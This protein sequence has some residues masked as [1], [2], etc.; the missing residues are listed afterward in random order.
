MNKRLA[1]WLFLACVVVV[2]DQGTKYLI[3]QWLS[4]GQ[5]VPVTPF[6][7]LV[8]VYNPGA[9]FSF[10]ADHSGWQ[11]WLFIVLTSSVSV[12]LLLLLRR[13]ASEC[14]LPLGLALILGGA[15]GNLIDR[16]LLGAVVDFLYF[17]AGNHG[18]PAFNVADSA[19]TAGVVLMLADQFGLAARGARAEK[20]A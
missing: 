10:L 4:F 3:T 8:L 9:A 1:G 2:L 18:F 16:V 13:H 5:R 14:L 6:F 15:V 7:D 20:E 12:W 11:R 19:I 17:H